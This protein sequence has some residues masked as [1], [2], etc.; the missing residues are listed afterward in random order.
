[1][2]IC[3]LGINYWPDKTG[4]APFTTGRAEYLAS[5]GHDVSVF[6]GFPYYPEWKVPTEYRGRAFAREM[7]NGVNIFRSWLHV[8][9]KVTGARRI[10]HEASFIASSLLR[11]GSAWKRPDIMF[12]VSPPLGLG[13]SAI[14]LA[15]MWKAP[16]V[17]H[18]ADLQPDAALDLGMLKPSRATKA[19]YAIER[20]AYRRAA[21]VSTLTRAIQ[22]KIAA[23]GIDR[24]RVVLMPD[25]TEPSLFEIPASG[26]GTKFKKEFG[27][28]NKFIVVH[29]GNMGVKQG[30]DVV[31]NAAD[32][33]QDTPD[34]VFAL[35]GDGATRAALERNASRRR[36]SNVKFI[37]LLSTEMFHQ[38]LAAADIALVTQKKEVGDIVFPS[39][40]LT[41]LAAA[42]PVIASVSA[43]S[44]IARVVT[45]CCA[46]VQVEPENPRALLDAIVAMRN[47]PGGRERAGLSGRAYAREHWDRGRVLGR[48]ERELQRL[49]RT[50]SPGI[51]TGPQAEIPVGD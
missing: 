43:G 40:I 30:L 50:C 20:A 28:E 10:L 42:R 13:L 36:I 27:L 45:E 33:A 17:F 12:V 3:V 29:A 2:R 24:S 32:M 46:G 9:R 48:F 21:A 41:L 44:E 15:G 23:K 35:V 49:A 1:M 39:K 37:S 38:M 8:P 34:L 14:M 6:T 4:I 5:C 18:V 31:L 47:D 7:R 19:L 51:S 22:E 16:Y 25:W 26:G 11:A